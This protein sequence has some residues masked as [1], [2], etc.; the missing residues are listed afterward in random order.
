MQCLQRIRHFFLEKE[1]RI[2]KLYL[3][4]LFQWLA[5]PPVL[6]KKTYLLSTIY[7]QGHI[8]VEDTSSTVR[9]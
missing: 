4:I 5:P 2:L 1:V 9:F 6:G 3:K 8:L 7:Y